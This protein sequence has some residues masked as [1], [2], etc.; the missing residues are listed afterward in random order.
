[1]PPPQISVTVDVVLEAEGMILLVR[2]RNDPFAGRWAL[3]GGFVEPDEDLPAAALRELE[4][5]TGVAPAGVDLTQLG[6]YG[7]PGRDPRGRTVSVVFL[8]RSAQLPNPVAADDAA[9]ARLFPMGALPAADEMAF[10]HHEILGDALAAL[11][12]AGPGASPSA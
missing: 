10:D 6:A 12:G 7:R 9:D 3:P 8:G 11:K 2:R 1:M 5:E 4:E